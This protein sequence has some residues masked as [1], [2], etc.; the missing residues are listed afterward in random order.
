MEAQ[1]CDPSHATPTPPPPHPLQTTGEQMDTVPEK[2]MCHV[3][4]CPVVRPRPQ[5]GEHVQSGPHGPS[6]GQ[7]SQAQGSKQLYLHTVPPLA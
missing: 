1:A 2:Q 7:V 5:K 4:S 3:A 6:S